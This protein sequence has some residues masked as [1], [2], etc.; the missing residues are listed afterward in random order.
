MRA[1]HRGAGALLCIVQISLTK[2]AGKCATNRAI[3]AMA[4][5][6]VARLF[7]KRRREARATFPG[8]AEI[9]RFLRAGSAQAGGVLHIL[10]MK[11][12][13][14]RTRREYT[15]DRQSKSMD[16][17][18]VEMSRRSATGKGSARRARPPR[19]CMR[20]LRAAMPGPGE[21]IRRTVARRRAERCHCIMG[22]L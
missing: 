11:R 1:V 5:R 19:G 18:A 16:R 3:R 6:G 7:L 13:D 14:D 15:E 12:L 10:P 17:G 8:S 21:K 22:I 20:C 9:A 4:A 2:A